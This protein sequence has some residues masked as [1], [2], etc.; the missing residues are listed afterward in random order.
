MKN[1]P[2][3]LA[4][5]AAALALATFVMLGAPADAA[6][7]THSTPDLAGSCSSSFTSGAAGITPA[8]GGGTSNFL[9]ADGTWS[10]PPSGGAAYSGISTAYSISVVGRGFD[11][12]VLLGGINDI[13]TDQTANTIE[14]NYGTG[15]I[16][17]SR[18]TRHA[19]TAWL[20]ILPFKNDSADWTPT[21]EAVRQAVNTFIRGTSG[22]IVVDVAA[23]FDDGN[24][25]LKAQY[26]GGDGLHLSQAGDDRIEFLVASALGLAP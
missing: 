26:D 13:R 18:D 2:S 22:V 20:T 6:G 21:R 19:T 11:T 8:S 16:A 7:T 23:D 4:G 9:R 3:L 17:D 12:L 1:A 14:L 24:G 25:A 15:I 10:A 5:L